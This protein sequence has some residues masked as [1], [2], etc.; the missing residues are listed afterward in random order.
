MTICAP[1][2][3]ARDLCI[4]ALGRVTGPDAG[5]HVELL[6]AFVIELQNPDVVNAAVDAA[7]RKRGARET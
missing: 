3:A 6:R 5:H 1:H 2:P 7:F 4:Q